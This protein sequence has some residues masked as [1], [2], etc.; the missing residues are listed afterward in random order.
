VILAVAVNQ[1]CVS[2]SVSFNKELLDKENIT[3][4]V[5][6]FYDFNKKEGNNSGILARNVF[7]TRL[8]NRGFK[9]KSIESIASELDY[10]LY[11]GDDYSK[12]WIIDAGKTC[13]ADYFIF[14]SVHDYRVFQYPTSFLYIF[15]WLETTYS[16]GIT[17][18][19]VSAKTGEAVWT[20]SLTKKSYT[21]TDAAEEVVNDFIKSM[22]LK[23]V[24][25]EQ[26]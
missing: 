2:S 14:G 1:S 3:I 24:V 16:V 12:D 15:S 6:P 17:A 26:P 9:V 13:K 23:P 21:F 22:K 18:R 25:K 4:A 19:M 20:G 7:E 8:V 10:Y 11:A 5:L